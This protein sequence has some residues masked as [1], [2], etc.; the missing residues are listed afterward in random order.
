MVTGNLSECHIENENVIFFSLHG[1]L[2]PFLA[3]NNDL[4]INYL[5]A[6]VW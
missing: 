2:E 1:V 5:V 6:H 4:I 3:L